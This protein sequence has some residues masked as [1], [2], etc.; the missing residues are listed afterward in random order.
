[1]SAKLVTGS[2]MTGAHCVLGGCSTV[3]RE[4]MDT[5]T[6]YDFLMED[7]VSLNILSDAEAFVYC[8]K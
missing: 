6:K 5:F 2:L 3:S 1:M 8:I 7:N 4:H